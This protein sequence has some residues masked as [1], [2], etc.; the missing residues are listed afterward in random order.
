MASIVFP[1][2]VGVNQLLCLLLC[3]LGGIPHVCGGEPTARNDS[4]RCVKNREH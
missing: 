3:L 2:C 4:R 1:T